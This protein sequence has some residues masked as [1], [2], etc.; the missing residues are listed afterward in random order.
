KSARRAA[1]F[2]TAGPCRRTTPG[3]GR[4]GWLAR[5]QG[6]RDPQRGS[7]PVRSTDEDSRPTRSAGL[8]P[9]APEPARA[10]RPRFSSGAAAQAGRAAYRPGAVT[11]VAGY[12]PGAVTAVAGYRPGTVT[13]VA[14]YRP[15]TVTDVAG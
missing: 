3:K 15:G 11:A 4:A 12:R 9:R 7:M 14:G 2:G 10:G 13:A 5:T 8:G 6:G 1:K